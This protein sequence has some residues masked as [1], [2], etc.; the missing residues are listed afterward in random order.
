MDPFK[1]TL[2]PKPETLKS[3]APKTLQQRL[4][5]ILD[6]EEH[7]DLRFLFRDLIGSG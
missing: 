6:G 3:L 5:R 7:A 4:G 1:G 2:N